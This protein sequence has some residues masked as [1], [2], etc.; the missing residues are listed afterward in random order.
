MA[1][2]IKHNTELLIEDFLKQKYT[3]AY[4]EGQFKD[5]LIQNGFKHLPTIYFS[6]I[7]KTNDKND[8]I[9]IDTD[10]YSDYKHNYYDEKD[11]AEQSKDGMWIY[12]CLINFMGSKGYPFKSEITKQA[13]IKQFIETLEREGFK[14]FDEYIKI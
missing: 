1:K 12:E 4:T 9:E 13:E 3:G 7:I 5:Y 10:I 11:F 2:L 6:V 14:N 8:I